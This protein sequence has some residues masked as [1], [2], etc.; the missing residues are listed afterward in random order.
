MADRLQELESAEMVG[1][2]DEW[3]QPPRKDAFMADPLTTPF[4]G[5][6]EDAR[7]R[8]VAA[9]VKA[10]TDLSAEERKARKVEQAALDDEF[11]SAMRALYHLLSALAIALPD[12]RAGYDRARELIFDNGLGIVNTNAANE[13][14]EVARI[15]RD[16]AAA[17]EVQAILTTQIGDVTLQYWFDRIVRVGPRLAAISARL[18]LDEGRSKKVAN[19]HEARQRFISIAASLRRIMPLTAL[20]EQQKQTLLD[21]LDK[22]LGRPAAK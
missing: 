2:C 11:D 5:L 18:N 1:I 16:V 12:R 21:P 7:E 15:E 8:L 17:P 3:Q 6:L 4:F 20:S 14:G 9:M 13:A 22:V 10:P 19:E